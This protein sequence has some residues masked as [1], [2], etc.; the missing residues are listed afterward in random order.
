MYWDDSEISSHN[1]SLTL[2]HENIIIVDRLDDSG[3][4][5]MFTGVLS[6]LSSN[7]SS[8]VGQSSQQPSWCSGRNPHSLSSSSITCRTEWGENMTVVSGYG[9]RGVGGA[10]IETNYS[11]GYSSSFPQLA[12]LQDSYGNYIPP[13]ADKAYGAAMSEGLDVNTSSSFSYQADISLSSSLQ[14]YPLSFF[15][16]LAI[17]STSISSCS[18]AA[19]LAQCMASYV[20]FKE[21]DTSQL[22]SPPP[23][24]VS[25]WV[26]EDWLGSCGEVSSSSPPSSSSIVVTSELGKRVV[27]S[28]VDGV[29]LS[30]TNVSYF[31]SLDGAEGLLVSDESSLAFS[32]ITSK[33]EE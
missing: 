32:S 22:Y 8:R 15:S 19:Q 18:H 5:S 10:V 11:I 23:Q 25:D 27:E 13:S 24:T 2:P 29:G 33:D 14:S 21:I 20:D 12:S 31:G 9:S 26:R 4:N 28:L 17:N 16:Y 30:S 7:F 1:P 6:S 3:V